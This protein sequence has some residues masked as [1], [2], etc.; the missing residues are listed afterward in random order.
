[1]IRKAK[2]YDVKEIQHLI[3]FYASRDTMLPRTMAELYE[4]LRDYFVYEEDGKVLGTCALHI[5]WEDLAEIKSLAVEESKQRQ[6]I[7]SN[8]LNQA[9]KEAKDLN[10]KRVFVLTYEPKFFRKFG[11]KE[12]DKAKLPQK[13]WGECINCVKFPDCEEIALIKEVK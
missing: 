4:N 13:I 12:V 1:M 6:G 10:I 7:G 8:L 2:I 9:L 3:N 11:F 5:C